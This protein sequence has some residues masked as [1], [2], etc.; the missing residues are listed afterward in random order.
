MQI[1]RHD[2]PN[3]ATGDHVVPLG[4]GGQHKRSNIR[5][6]CKSCNSRKGD[7]DAIEYSKHTGRLMTN[8]TKGAEDE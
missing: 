5:A 3:Y 2:Q 4:K 1:F 6:V 7:K 8:L